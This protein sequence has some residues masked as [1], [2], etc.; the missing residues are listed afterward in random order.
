MTPKHSAQSE[1]SAQ[2]VANSID[3][4]TPAKSAVSSDP[5]ERYPEN[6]EGAQKT[7]TDKKVPND[8][9]PNDLKT[10]EAGTPVRVTGVPGFTIQH[11]SKR[12]KRRNRRR[13]F[14]PSRRGRP[15]RTVS[16]GS[17]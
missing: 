13:G 1:H 6:E 10:E 9:K 4:R 3:N 17:R 14:K 11:F 15:S 16:G 7:S 8:P 2:S 5:Q 12:A